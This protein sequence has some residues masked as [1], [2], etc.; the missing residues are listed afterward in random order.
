MQHYKWQ[1]TVSILTTLA[2][3][4]ILALGSVLALPARAAGTGSPNAATPGPTSTRLAPKGAAALFG[5]D[6]Q[7]VLAGNPTPASQAANTGVKWVRAEVSWNDF[8]PTEGVFDFTSTDRNMTTLLNAGLTP[9]VYLA[10][11]PSWAANT[12]CG[13]IDTT[14]PSMVAAFSDAVTALVTHYPQITIFAL[15][16][17][18]DRSTKPNTGGAGCFGSDNK[19]GWNHNGVRDSDEYAIMLAT[20]WKAVH[21]ANPKAKLVTGAFA[22]D[23][24]DKKSAPPGYPG[25]GSGGTFNYTFMD[26]L[27]AYMKAHPLPNKQKYMDMLVFNYYDRYGTYY[28][29]SVAP[30]YGI[31]AKAAYIVNRMEAN[32]I[33]LVPLFVTE[34]G[35]NAASMGQAAQA[36]CLDMTLVRGT[37]SKLKGMVWWTYRDNPSNTAEQFGIVDQGELPKLSFAALKTLTTELNGF[38]YRGNWSNSTGFEEVEAYR[39]AKKQSAKMVVWSASLITK[40]DYSQAC[41]WSRNPRRVTFD[42][43]ALRVVDYLGKAKKI[44]DNSK[45]DLDSRVG[46]IAFNVTDKPQIVQL[47]P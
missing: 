10:E 36:H 9:V 38:K 47:N 40:T 21:A 25:G 3:L 23:N 35:E 37:A 33:P 32:Q 46:K 28:W 6:E 22:Y 42:A 44:K 30:G 43:Q 17:E 26:D 1:V 29:E 34:T 41:S 16:N 39:F 19:N 12:K 18:T 5:I 4:G 14:N 7:G 15:Y 31:Q 11:N 24:F 8:E 13:P 20:A 2:V 27:F 45:R